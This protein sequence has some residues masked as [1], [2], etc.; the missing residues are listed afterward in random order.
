MSFPTSQLMVTH[1]FFDPCQSLA[2]LASDSSLGRDVQVIHCIAKINM[3]LK[4]GG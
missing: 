1:G 2:Q 3:M 4:I